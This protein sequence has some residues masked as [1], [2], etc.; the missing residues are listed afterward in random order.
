[1][2]YAHFAEYVVISYS[3]RTDMLNDSVS[4]INALAYGTHTVGLQTVGSQSHTESSSRVHCC[5]NTRPVITL[6]LC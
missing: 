2:R 5:D 1:M 6:T 3:H 4:L